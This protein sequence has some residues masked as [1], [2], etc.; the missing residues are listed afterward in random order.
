LARCIGSEFNE[1]AKFY[2][3]G[4]KVDYLTSIG[5]HPTGESM[6]RQKDGDVIVLHQPWRIQFIAS[7][8][9]EDLILWTSNIFFHFEQA[10]K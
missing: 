1:Q 6:V 5:S 4:G 2:V 9:F 8:Y 10:C 7:Y 3:N